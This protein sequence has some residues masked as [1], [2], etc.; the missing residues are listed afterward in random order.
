M[1]LKIKRLLSVVLSLVM[2]MVMLPM[3][4]NAA[5]AGDKLYV[6]PNS[7]WAIDNARFAAY[8]FGA[9]SAWT[10]CTLV[11]GEENIY[12]C[13]IPEG[14]WTHVIFCRMNPSSTTNDWNYKWNQTSDLALPTDDKNF[15]VLG[16]GWDNVTYTWNVYG[17]EVEEPESTEGYFVRGLGGDWN[18]LTSANK[19]QEVDGVYT[20][21]LTLEAGTHE[22]KIADATWSKSWPAQNYSLTLEEATDVT[23]SYDPATDEGSVVYEEPTVDEAIIYQTRNNSDVRLIAFVNDLAAYS[24]VSFTLTIDG[25]ESEA[26]ECTTAYSG[27]YADETLYTTKDI[28]GVDGYFVTYTINGY[29]GRYAGKEVTITATY[30]TVTGETSTDVRTVTI[31]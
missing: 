10:D 17:G 6:Q 2:I 9:G 25:N 20:L 30:T 29:F 19:L 3:T 27:L 4:A 23:F 18:T 13:T 16:D 22:F 1:R 8:F 28:Y 21:T 24:S 7:N 14:N 31:G 11:E 26:L 5:T 15:C 12:E